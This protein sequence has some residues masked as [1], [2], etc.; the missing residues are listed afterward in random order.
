MAHGAFANRNALLCVSTFLALAGFTGSSC[1]A[2][3]PIEAPPGL[4][5]AIAKHDD[6]KAAIRH[7]LYGSALKVADPSSYDFRYAPRGLK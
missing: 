2:S 6:K 7:R 4:R 1:A 3:P 5:A